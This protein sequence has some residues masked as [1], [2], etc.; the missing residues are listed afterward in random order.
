MR[1]GSE[2]IPHHARRST[3]F[4]LCCIVFCSDVFEP[5]F[6]FSK[7]AFLCFIVCELLRQ[8][9]CQL[10]STVF[11]GCSAVFQLCFILF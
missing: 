3:V 6:N 1:S 4:Q 7:S 8:L 9:L 5:G 2:P 10:C 11:Q